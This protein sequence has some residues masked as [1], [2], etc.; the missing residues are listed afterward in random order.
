MRLLEDGIG[1][2]LFVRGT[3]GLVLTA[4]GGELLKGTRDAMRRV[5]DVVAAEDNARDHQR[6]F[7]AGA[8][9]SVLP[10]MLDLALAAVLRASE[11]THV[12]TM[13]LD[14][15]STVDELLR[16]NLDLALV[17]AAAGIEPSPDITCHVLGELE[18]AVLAPAS[19]PLATRVG[20]VTSAE[21]DVAKVVRLALPETQV[22]PERS[23]EE[24]ASVASIGSADRLAAQGPFLAVLPIALASVGFR[25]LAPSSERLTALAL[26][27]APLE[28]GVPPLVGALVAALAVVMAR[29]PEE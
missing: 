13:H 20:R 6:V 29:R 2:P 28:Q 1:Q 14:A 3:S 12:R 21:V 27:R 17:D 4:F 5:H 10:R 15:E 19:H 25:A 23:Q 18:F 8:H 26:F 16:G 24:V 7:V 11:G 22:R 9:G